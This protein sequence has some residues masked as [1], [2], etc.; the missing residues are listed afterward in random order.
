MIDLKP[1]AHTEAV[2]YFRSKGFAPQLQRFSYLDLWGEE[3]ARNFVVAKAMRD[4]VA[5][6]I[7]AELDRAI[8]E[9][10]TLNQFQ[11][12]LQPALERVGW[13]GK[14][15]MTDPLTGE[16]QEVQLGSPRRLRVIYDTNMR[17]A[18]A[19]GHWAR[20]QRTK[21]A[22]PY[23]QYL[24]IQ[25]PSK[26]HDHAR[27]HDRI[28]RVDDPIWQRI[29]PPNG[30]FC[31]CTVIQRTEGW[32]R[33]NGRQV[34]ETLDLDERPWINPRSGDVQEVPAGVTPGF[35]VNPG[36]AWLDLGENWRRITPDLDA[37][38]QAS[39]QGVVEGLRLLRVAEGREALVIL[40]DRSEPVSEQRAA[41]SLPDRV[42]T[43]GL[44]IPPGATFLHSHISESSLSTDDL[45]LLE[46]EAGYA[47]VAIT[48]GGSIWRAKREGDALL[49][50]AIGQFSE[51][52]TRFRDELQANPDGAEIFNHARLLWLERKGLITYGYR[53]SERTRQIMERNTDLLERLTDAIA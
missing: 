46:N 25:R 50:P 12:D 47:M 22:F 53:M 32:M 41:A 27:F 29:Y 3:H 45:F 44:E 49:R 11:T 20:I 14:S 24:Q 15:V 16:V 4:D 28:W 35:D 30:Y 38:R 21:S 10:R 51:V 33:R 37:G 8:S 36:A 5:E 2:A 19:A 52:L 23:L 17:T 48:P 31:G 7:R 13:W 26:R 40:N 18:H 1:L 34:S 9:G 39:E 42:S 43:D 6:M